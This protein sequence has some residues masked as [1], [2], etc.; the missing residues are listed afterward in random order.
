MNGTK[1]ADS[2]LEAIMKTTANLI[3]SDNLNA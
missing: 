3:D 1:I 2:V